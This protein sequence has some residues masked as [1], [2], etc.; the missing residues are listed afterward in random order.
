MQL[1]GYSKVRSICWV[2]Y[3]VVA[4]ALISCASKTTR[5]LEADRNFEAIVSTL[6]LEG[7]LID[8]SGNEAHR[9]VRTHLVNATRF[10][11]AERLGH[12]KVRVLNADEVLP[13][14]DAALTKSAAH[15]SKWG[16]FPVRLIGRNLYVVF[17][18]ENGQPAG[19]LYGR[20]RHYEV[21]LGAK[22]V[23]PGIIVLSVAVDP[24]VR[25]PDGK[26]LGRKE[27]VGGMSRVRICNQGIIFKKDP[28]DMNL[29]NY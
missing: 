1:S 12:R 6:P 29:E 15:A 4:L 10:A 9:Q 14:I 21:Y 23:K 19:A 20:D 25:A 2:V 13:P 27:F 16:E 24:F 7:P 8:N 28:F 11:F 18:D 3:S 17:F 5:S 22:P 26:F